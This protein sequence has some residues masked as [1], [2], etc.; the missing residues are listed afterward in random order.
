MTAAKGGSEPIVLVVRRGDEFRTLTFD[1]HDGLRYPRLV[2]TEGSR[3]RLADILAPR[4][5]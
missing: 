5:R 3:D 2:R 1:Y 4:R